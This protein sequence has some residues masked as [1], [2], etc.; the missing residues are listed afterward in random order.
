ML[1]VSDEVVEGALHA[2]K[3]DGVSVLLSRVDGHVRAVKN[4]CP[5]FGIV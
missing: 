1:A 4:N 5:H 2:V 3:K